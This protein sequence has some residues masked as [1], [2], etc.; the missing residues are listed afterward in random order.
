MT[1]RTQALTARRPDSAP[2]DQA[3]RRRPQRLPSTRCAPPAHRSE[4][5]LP[6]VAARRRAR[7]PRP[8]RA[9]AL[10]AAHTSC[11]ACALPAVPR[12]ERRP[13]PPP[14]A[15]SGER[16]L[17]AL[18]ASGTSQGVPLT[19]RWMDGRPPVAWAFTLVTKHEDLDLRLTLRPP[20]SSSTSSSSRRTISTATTIPCSEGELPRPPNLQIRTHLRRAGSGPRRA[21]SPSGSHTPTCVSFAEAVSPGFSMRYQSRQGWLRLGA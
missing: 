1:T 5:S 10:G 21:I 19:T 11:P 3:R 4:R 20:S 13:G 16:S 2:R 14:P 9:A 8:H 7:N 15:R 17:P 18:R 6:S 12:R